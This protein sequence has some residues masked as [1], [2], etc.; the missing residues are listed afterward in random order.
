MVQKEKVSIIIPLYNGKNFIDKTLSIIHKIKAPKEIIVIND[1][2]TDESGHYCIQLKEKYPELIVCHKKN[3]GI[4]TAR[5][6][7]LTLC[8]G[9]YILFVDQDD[10]IDPNNADYAIE[11]VRQKKLDV[12]FWSCAYDFNGKIAN[13]DII[14]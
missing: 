5:N 3:G 10:Y 1:G 8:T 7:G 4:F 13:R 12:L 9:D 6:M 11:F 2:S 14:L